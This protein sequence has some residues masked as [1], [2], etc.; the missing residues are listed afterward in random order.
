MEEVRK[1][2]EKLKKI[3]KK[4]KKEGLIKKYYFRMA[5]SATGKVT[6]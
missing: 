3:K 5:G 1:S 4:R 2:D 6:E